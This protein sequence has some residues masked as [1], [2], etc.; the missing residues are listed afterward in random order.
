MAVTAGS[1]TTRLRKACPYFYGLIPNDIRDSEARLMLED[2]MERM[3]ESKVMLL[4]PRKAF[5]LA[6]DIIKLK[7]L[8]FLELLF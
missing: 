2:V 3:D 4:T 1:M 7:E 8:L 6:R 5:A